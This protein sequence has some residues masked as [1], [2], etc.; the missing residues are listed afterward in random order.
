VSKNRDHSTEK[1]AHPA[2]AEQPGEGGF[3]EGQQKLPDNKRVGQFSDGNE[4]LPDA[5]HVGQFSDGNESRPDDVREGKFS[6]SA[7]I[8]N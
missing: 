3:E 8:E 5:E 1:Q 4:E 7:R 6:D 2:R